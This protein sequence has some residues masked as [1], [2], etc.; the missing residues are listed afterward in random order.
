MPTLGDLLQQFIRGAGQGIQHNRA[1]AT[2]GGDYML[3]DEAAGSA[4]M[5]ADMRRAVAIAEAEK[6]RRRLGGVAEQARSEFPELTGE[7][8]AVAAR[9]PLMRGQQK[10]ALDEAEAM[11]AIDTEG[12]RQEELG[13]R[14]LPRQFNDQELEKVAAEIAKLK[15]QTRQADAA[16][17]L[18]N[19]RPGVTPPRATQPRPTSDIDLAR[20]LMRSMQEG[21]SQEEQDALL[22]MARGGKPVTDAQDA[23]TQQATPGRG[24]DSHAGGNPAAPPSAAKGA[25]P[26]VAT[27]QDFDRLPVGALF[28]KGGRPCVKVDAGKMDCR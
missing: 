3:K 9:L 16:A 24:P 23:P 1:V 18:S 22:E 17:D 8:E 28:S 20:L 19:R 26:E 2:R 12:A 27:R 10:A 25:P 6:E 15:A 14:H 11:A 4:M 21:M 7:D 13:Q 5:D